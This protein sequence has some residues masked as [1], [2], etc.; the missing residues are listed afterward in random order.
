MIYVHDIIAIASLAVRVSIAYKDAPAD[1][2]HI[3]KKVAA[4]KLLIDRSA[5]HFKRS[6]ISQEDY[7]YGEKVLKSCQGVLEDLGSLIEKY[8]RLASINKRHVLNRVKICKDITALQVR[9]TS[10]TVLFNGFIRRCVVH[11][12]NPMDVN[13]SI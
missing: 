1:Y 12:I 2:R 3:S 8:K 5:P 9:L 13:T 11:F 4:L 6:T 10:N 7:H